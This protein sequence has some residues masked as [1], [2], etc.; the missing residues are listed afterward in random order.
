[1]TS[2]KGEMGDGM[3]PVSWDI[4]KERK[5]VGDV[6]IKLLS[7]IC[8][9]YSDSDGWRQIGFSDLCD[10]NSGDGDRRWLCKRGDV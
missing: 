3:T 9:A 7:S 2:Q 4:E 1:M 8:T 10:R 5:K 6:M